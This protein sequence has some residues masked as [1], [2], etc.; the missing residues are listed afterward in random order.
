MKLNLGS[1]KKRIDGYISCDLHDSDMD[2]DIRKLPFDDNTIDEIIA[3]HVLEHFYV[4][5]IMYVLHEWKRVL[6][7]DAKLIVELPCFDKVV[8]LL[9][10]GIN[11]YFCLCAFYGSP[12]THKDGEPALHKWCWSKE[13]FKKL[14]ET[15]GFRNVVDEPPVYH[16][17]IRDMRFVCIK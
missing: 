8:E 3:I 7:P 5:E 11:D 10:S 16:H 6:K 1:G 9:K 4:H 15:V 12:K 14:L 2:M 13:Q 17:Q